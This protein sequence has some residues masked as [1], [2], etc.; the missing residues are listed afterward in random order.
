LGGGAAQARTV[1]LTGC[2]ANTFQRLD[3]GLD[4]CIRP[5]VS[6][7]SSSANTFQRLR[8]VHTR[9]GNGGL[10]R[11]FISEHFPTFKSVLQ[12]ESAESSQSLLHQRTL[13]NSTTRAWKW[14][15]PRGL[16][17][18]FISE[19]FP[20][21]TSFTPPAWRSPCLNRFFISE[22]FPTIYMK[23]ERV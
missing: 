11:F 5:Y 6:I 12:E 20:T 21:A 2:K 23:P 4:I 18:F 22:H 3:Q 19:H 7:A 10:N 15:A 14:R 17:R 16:N 13:S 1:D 8:V 9:I